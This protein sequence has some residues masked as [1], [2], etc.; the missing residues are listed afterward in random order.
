MIWS[1][2]FYGMIIGILVVLS[3]IIDI[4]LSLQRYIEFFPYKSLSIL[5][6]FLISLYFLYFSVVKKYLFSKKDAIFIV[7]LIL[8]SQVGLGA[9]IDLSDLTVF[10]ILFFFLINTFIDSDYKIKVPL[11]LLLLALMFFIV[12]SGSIPSLFKLPSV[13]KSILAFFLMVNLIRSKE[14]AF[15]AIKVFIAIT[16]CSAIIGIAQEIIF[17]TTGLSL[18]GFVSSKMKDLMYTSTSWGIFLRVPA[19]TGWYLLLTNYLIIGIVLIVNLLLYPIVAKKRDRLV[20]YGAL[21]IMSVGL[22]FTFSNSGE[23][24]VVIGVILS[25]F[26]KW[27]RFSI[28]FLMASLALG[29]FAYLTGIY[30]KFIETVA[31]EIGL[32]GDL[33][34]RLRLLHDGI[35]GFLYRHPFTGTGIDMGAQYTQNINNWPVHNMLVLIADELGMFG[36][37]IYLLLVI[38]IFVYLL[39]CI[40]SIKDNGGKFIIIALLVSLIALFVNIQFHPT[41]KDYSLFMIYGMFISIGMA[42]SKNKEKEM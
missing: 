12:L 23:L 16:T 18:V 3:P 9:K 34:V 14:H 25:I 22:L 20:M 38:G 1:P 29:I 36:L 19:L 6:L 24:S 31:Y 28:H 10:I 40:Q 5:M 37:M 7:L 4:I 41:Y 17:L 39:N 13:L 2:I 27:R 33:G 26:I 21:I 8:S 15:F 30:D 32:C 42:I 11:H 35:E